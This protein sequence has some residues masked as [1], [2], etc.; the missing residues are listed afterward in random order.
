MT[1]RIGST[2][3]DEKQVWG[4]RDSWQRTAAM[5][6]RIVVARWIWTLAVLATS[7]GLVVVLGVA[8]CLTGDAP[9]GP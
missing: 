7:V 2:W 8:A 9:G 6:W 5:N 1:W 4:I 3:A